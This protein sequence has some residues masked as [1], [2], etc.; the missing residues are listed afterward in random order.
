[1]ARLSRLAWGILPILPALAAVMFL[2]DSRDTARLCPDYSTALPP[3]P[4]QCL[5]TLLPSVTG[6]DPVAIG[7]SWL[8]V[9][10]VIYV[11]VLTTTAVVRTRGFAVPGPANDEVRRNAGDRLNAG[12]SD[13][14]PPSDHAQQSRHTRAGRNLRRFHR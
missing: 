13:R 12:T 2:A 6:A 11:A 3:R 14:L 1:M 9:G 7:L 4:E 8:I 10:V 5:P